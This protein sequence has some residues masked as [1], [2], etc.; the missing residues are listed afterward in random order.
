MMSNWI[1]RKATR[2]D[3]ASLIDLWR[4][5]FHTDG[6]AFVDWYFQA[7][8]NYRET[9]VAT[10][11][12]G[13]IIGSAQLIQQ[14]IRVGDEKIPG[15]YVVGVNCLPE[16]RGRGVVGTVMNWIYAESGEELL[17]LMPFEESFYHKKFVFFDW[18]GA[19][20]LPLSELQHLAINH[21]DILERFNLSVGMA[22]ELSLNDCYEFWQKRYFSFFAERDHRRWMSIIDDLAIE[23]GSVALHKCGDIVD[24]YVL[25]RVVEDTIHIREMAYCNRRVREQLYYFLYSHRS[26]C[27]YIEW[28]AP[29]DEALVRYRLTDKDNVV[30]HPFMMVRLQDPLWSSKFAEKR[31]DCPYVFAIEND[32]DDSVKTYFWDKQSEKILELSSTSRV[33]DFSISLLTLNK[34]IFTETPL[35]DLIDAPQTVIN[36]YSAFRQFA[37][38]FKKKRLILMSIFRAYI[39]QLVFGKVL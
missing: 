9:V 7:Y 23:N 18:H 20:H 39:F 26:Q 15:V 25:Y 6:D 11:K 38:L 24:G 4:I 21:N 37:S 2:E 16:Y 31:P 19:L 28:S 3:L 14:T 17:F 22:E 35:A 27:K 36:D 30:F 8:Y 13:V 1:I 12:E 10:T 34:L 5:C 33:P 32:I 29:I